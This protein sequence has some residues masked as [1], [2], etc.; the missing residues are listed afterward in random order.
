[1]LGPSSAWFMPFILCVQNSSDALFGRQTDPLVFACKQKWHIRNILYHQHGQIS[2]YK[3]NWI[4]FTPN[5]I[6]PLNAELNPICHLLEWLGGATIVV[7]SRLRVNDTRCS[8]F[9]RVRKFE[10]SYY[11]LRHVRPSVRPHGTTRLPMDGFSWN[12]IFED[13]SKIYWE[14][15]GVVKIGKE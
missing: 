3:G 15:L 2:V 7:V 8:S 1:M 13:F 12:L 10:K 11:K 14:N 4:I 9:R 6:N 5:R